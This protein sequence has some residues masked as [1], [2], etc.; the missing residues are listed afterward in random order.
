MNNYFQNEFSSQLLCET[1][2]HPNIEVGAFSYYSGFASMPAS[3]PPSELWSPMEKTVQE[4]KTR[5]QLR[6]VKTESKLGK[7]VTWLKTA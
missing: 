7:E 5:P 4:E 1:V 6:V 2:T 3:K